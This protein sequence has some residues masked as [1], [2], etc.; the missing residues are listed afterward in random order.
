LVIQ[1]GVRKPGGIRPGFFA[2]SETGLHERFD[3][4]MLVNGFKSGNYEKR[5]DADRDFESPVPGVT[6]ATGS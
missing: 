3:F 2:F 5:F 1:F 6:G 4:T